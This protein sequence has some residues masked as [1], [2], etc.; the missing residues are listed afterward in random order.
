MIVI[1][2]FF[3]LHD[4]NKHKYIFSIIVLQNIPEKKILDKTR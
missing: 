1:T 2:F 3:K 4:I